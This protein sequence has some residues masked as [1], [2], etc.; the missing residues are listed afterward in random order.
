MNPSNSSVP[1]SEIASSNAPSASPAAVRP[2]GQS[3]PGWTL[4]TSHDVN[5]NEAGAGGT[6]EALRQATVLSA[7]PP[8]VAA[9]HSDQTAQR[10]PDDKQQQAQ[11]QRGNAR[12]DTDQLDPRIR[13]PFREI[14]LHKV[15]VVRHAVGNLT[16]TSLPTLLSC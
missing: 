12:C 2:L 5:D 4:N 8:R 3:E 16:E 11:A 6:S 7:L 10:P 13:I 15:G 1:R 9:T 14:T